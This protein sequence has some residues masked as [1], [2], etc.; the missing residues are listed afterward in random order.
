MF[1]ESNPH[2]HWK[3]PVYLLE[4]VSLHWD[5]LQCLL[6]D[7]DQFSVLPA[8]TVTDPFAKH[9]CPPGWQLVFSQ[10]NPP[11][12]KSLPSSTPAKTDAHRVYVACISDYE[13]LRGP[14]INQTGCRRKHSPF[15]CGE[16]I[17]TV[18]YIRDVPDLILSCKLALLRLSHLLS[19]LLD[20]IIKQSFSLYHVSSL[21][22]IFTL[23]NITLKTLYYPTDAQIYNS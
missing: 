23:S 15:L 6:G 1:Q 17:S 9:P 2:V 20:W 7:Q 5:R 14:G 13:K 16:N 12:P 10:I 22:V 11:P 21:F 3:M 18:T 19:E 4:L 8:N